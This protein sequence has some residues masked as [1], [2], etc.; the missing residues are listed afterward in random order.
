MVPTVRQNFCNK[1]MR[2]GTHCR[3]CSES[4]K[5]AAPDTQHHVIADCPAYEDIRDQFDMET[6]RGLVKFFKEVVKRRIEKG[7]A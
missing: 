4:G 1:Y 2:E 5:P 3:S 6:D 7:E